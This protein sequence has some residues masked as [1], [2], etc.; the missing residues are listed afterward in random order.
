MS[1][2]A[3]RPASLAE[4]GG[5]PRVAGELAIILDSARKRSKLPDHVL[6]AGPPG[7]G[8]TTL[9][10]I[11]AHEL[12]L[13]FVATTGPVLDKPA[14]IISLM[15]TLTAPSVVFIDEI[16]RLPRN[17]EELLYPAMEDG[18]IDLVIGEGA[19]SRPVR[20]PLQPFVLVG[21]TTQTGLLSAPLRD[22][23]GYTAKL[24]LYEDDALAAI[25]SRSA[26]LLGVTVDDT[27]AKVI[28]SRSR[29]TPRIANSNLRRVRDY[30]EATGAEH[31]DGTVAEAALAAFHIDTL[32][33]DQAGRD[34]I[35]ILVTRFNGGPVGLGTLASAVGEA[36]LTVEEVYEP[37]L[38]RQGLIARTA[39]GR[40]ATTRAYEHLGVAAPAATLAA[41]VQPTFAFDATDE[42]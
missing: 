16:H 27:A 4:F 41:D 9:A 38:L 10:A 33:L 22:R 20:L 26:R 23:F 2:D 30:V 15:T 1:V 19:R 21:A 17:V 24:S 7:L 37:F 14:A 25:I 42:L 36:P 40:V 39:R 12:K 34:I 11:V 6:F 28:A 35:N 31:V 3:L 13:G 8:K 18:V 5:Q 29:G 32:G